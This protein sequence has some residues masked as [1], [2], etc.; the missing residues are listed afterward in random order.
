MTN[1]RLIVRAVALCAANALVLGFAS[2]WA[3]AGVA[4][5]AVSVAAVGGGGQPAADGL[6]GSKVAFTRLCLIAGCEESVEHQQAEIWT[7]NADGSDP[8]Q[9]T[10]N[11]TWDLGAVWSADG[12]TVAFYGTRFDPI[13]DQQLGPPHVYLADASS[14]EQTLLSEQPGR[15]P[16][17]SPNGGRIAFDNGGQPSANIFV[18]NTDGSGLGQLTHDAAARNIRPD[19]SPDGRKIAFTSRRD[20]NDEIYVMN[21]DGTDQTRL[22]DNPASDLAPAWSPDGRKIVFQ[23]DRDGNEEI[24]VMNADG[25]DQTRLTDYPGR[26]EDPDWS[27]N[28]RSIAF[29]RD[30]EPIADRILEVFV[31]NADGTNQMPL[32]GLPSENGHPGW[33][34]GPALAP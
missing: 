34:R 17:F 28:G 7:M 32:T 10:H 33:G 24:Y 26:D 3:G 6:E 8:R 21:A 23:S 4:S 11:T 31:M 2:P 5:I 18:I 30:I 29:H 22:T 13:T 25:S 9:L 19:W 1:K 20:G 27:P 16:S 12:K 15:W 14:G